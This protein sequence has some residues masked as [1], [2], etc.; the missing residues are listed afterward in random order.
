MN[1]LTRINLVLAAA[2]LL[3]GLVNWLEP[4]LK[5]QAT[6][7]VS[8]L[9]VDSVRQIKLYRQQQLAVSLQREE[10]G[11]VLQPPLHADCV[12]SDCEIRRPELI[13][14]W[15]HFAELPSLH[16]FAAPRERLGEFGL[17][18]P[19]YQLR[20]DDL[21]ILVGSLDPGSRLRYMMVKGQI[22]LVSDSYYHTLEQNP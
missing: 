4:G 13:Q 11:W 1:P 17:D 18:K 10:G 12:N 16:S 5:Q 8:A 3:L 22:H 9:D 7:F 2:V 19:A 14:Q 20:L 21:S 15:L 6:E